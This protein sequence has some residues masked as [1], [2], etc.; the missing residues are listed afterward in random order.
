ME[1]VTDWKLF[2]FH[3]SEE[4]SFMK[5]AFFDSFDPPKKI[6]NSNLLDQNGNF[7]EGL[8]E[9]HYF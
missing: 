9:V 3:D 7:Y 2:L 8:R 6:T 4:D 5:K 1:W